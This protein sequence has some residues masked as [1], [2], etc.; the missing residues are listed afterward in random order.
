MTNQQEYKR[1]KESSKIDKIIIDRDLCIGASPC[2]A[3]SAETF[4]LDDEN[5]AIVIDADAADDDTLIQAA[6]SCPTL[7][8]KL[9]DKDGHDYEI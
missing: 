9:L 5:I 6:Q 8:I 2:I 7:A 1:K 3:V 4:T